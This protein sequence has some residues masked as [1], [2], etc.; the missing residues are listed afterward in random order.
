[1]FR[2]KENDRFFYFHSDV[3]GGVLKYFKSSHQANN[4]CTYAKFYSYFYFILFFFLGGWGYKRIP[5]FP[6]ANN[7]CT[8]ENYGGE[9]LKLLTGNF[10]MGGVFFF[11]VKRLEYLFY[12]KYEIKEPK[13][14]RFDPEI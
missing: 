2:T 4:D 13:L 14:T 12:E 8:E 10:K 9:K 3:E 6:Q 5:K 7:G 1:M 11:L